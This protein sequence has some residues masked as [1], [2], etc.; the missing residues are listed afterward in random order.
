MIKTLSKIGWEGGRSTSI[1]IMSL[2]ILG[3][4]WRLPLR[5]SEMQILQRYTANTS[6]IS[7]LQDVENFQ[8]GR[9][10]DPVLNKDVL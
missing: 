9:F 5:I 6:Q 4:F 2:D 10:I 3:F 1:W 7:K 8:K